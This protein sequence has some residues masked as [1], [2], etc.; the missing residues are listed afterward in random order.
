MMR[1]STGLGVFQQVPQIAVEIFEH[2]DR[3][4]RFVAG[5]FSETHAS[6]G[7]GG[8]IA[9]EIIGGEEQEDAARR[10][11]ADRGRLFGRGGAGEEDRGP[12]RRRAGRADGNP[13]FL[14]LGLIGILNEREAELADVEGKRLVIITD[15][16]G[17]V[18]EMGH[19]NPHYPL[20]ESTGIL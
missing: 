6:G 8:M 5:A 17:D 9:R 14:L 19:F 1:R 15:E 18:G 10:L 4:V 12:V 7:E 16:Q 11:V 20:F 3:A 2:R 13:A